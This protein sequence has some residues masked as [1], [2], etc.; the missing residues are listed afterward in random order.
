MKAQSPEGSLISG[1]LLLP[2]SEDELKPFRPDLGVKSP[3]DSFKNDAG[4]V[5]YAFDF[6]FA[7]FSESSRGTAFPVELI[8]R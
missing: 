2:E 7:L 6:F 3:Y 8:P 1:A 4:H 5:F